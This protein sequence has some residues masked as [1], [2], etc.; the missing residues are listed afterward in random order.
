M[1]EY[2]LASFFIIALAF[3]IHSNRSKKKTYDAELDKLRNQ[4]REKDKII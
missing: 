2:L 4:I 1:R 3:F